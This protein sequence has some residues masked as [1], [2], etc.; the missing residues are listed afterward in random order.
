MSASWIY[1]VMCLSWL[2]PCVAYSPTGLYD[3]KEQCIAAGIEQLKHQHRSVGYVVK[4]DEVYSA[5]SHESLKALEGEG[6]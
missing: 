6:K 2:T 4:C 1:T 3:T 5:L